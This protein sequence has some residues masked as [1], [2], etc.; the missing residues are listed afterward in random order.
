MEKELPKEK[1]GNSLIFHHLYINKVTFS[2]INYFYFERLA[3]HSA[4]NSKP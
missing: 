4:A 3:Y 2:T 1:I